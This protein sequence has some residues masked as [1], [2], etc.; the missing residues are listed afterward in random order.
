MN[1]KL[2]Y[3]VK[4]VSEI[5]HTNPTYV[6]QLINAKLLPALKLGSYKVR[7]EALI[8]FLQQYEG[9]DLTNPNNIVPL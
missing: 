4:E 9:Q 6:Y 3:T 8:N 2:L 7:H 5:I 1:S